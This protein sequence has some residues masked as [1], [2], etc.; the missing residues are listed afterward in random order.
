METP[1]NTDVDILYVLRHKDGAV[2]LYV[3]E[4]WAAE[5]GVDPSKLERVEIPKQLY[6]SGTV[7]ELREYVA[8]YLESKQTGSS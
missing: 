6:T 1:E 5:R 8:T 7:Q 4:D 3:D 2:S